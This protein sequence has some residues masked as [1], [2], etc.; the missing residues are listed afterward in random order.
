MENRLIALKVL[1]DTLGIPD[2]IETID[3]RKRVQKAV[4]LGQLSDVNLGYRFG[5]YV[6]GPYSPALTK[7]YF[8]LAE[9]IASGDKGYEGKEFTPG[10]LGR[11]RRILPLM[12]LLSRSLSSRR[13]GWNWSHRY[14]I[15]GA[16]SAQIDRTRL[17]PCVGR[18][19]TFSRTPK[20]L[21]QLSCKRVS[22]PQ[23]KPHEAIPG[24][25]SR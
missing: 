17:K 3:D 18:S 2:T 1:L 9:A 24:E 23:N 11:I 22:F 21:K 5:W 10:V 25:A 7:D 6:L 20:T 13:T 4:Y 12:R 15:S 8:S 16:L 14:I 19:L